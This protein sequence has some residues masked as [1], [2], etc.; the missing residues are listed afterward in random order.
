MQGP[1]SHMDDANS[2]LAKAQASGAAVAEQ[3]VGAAAQ[4][5]GTEL[6]SKAHRLHAHKLTWRRA[7][8]TSSAGAQPV[9]PVRPSLG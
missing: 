8:G 2:S 9:P 6:R 5:A 3:V 7:G 1:R 4:P